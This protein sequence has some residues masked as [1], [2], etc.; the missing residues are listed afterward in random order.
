MTQATTTGSQRGGAPDPGGR[1]VHAFLAVLAVSLA[2]TSCSKAPTAHEAMQT[3]YTQLNTQSPGWRQHMRERNSKMPALVARYTAV[4]MQDQHFKL[5][6]RC[7]ETD[8]RCYTREPR[9]WESM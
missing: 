2:L 3:C 6:A 4:C 7:S 8:E 1:R 9:W 5:A